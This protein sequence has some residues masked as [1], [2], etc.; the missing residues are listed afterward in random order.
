MQAAGIAE[1]ASMA[2]KRGSYDQAIK[3]L[4]QAEE[5]APELPLVF[6]YRANVAYLMGDKQA[7]IAALEKA[8]QLEPDNIFYREN[9][10]RLRES[11]KP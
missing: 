5:M 6:Q 1:A 4:D 11:P 7:A 2:A 10:K 8:I 3:L 9:L